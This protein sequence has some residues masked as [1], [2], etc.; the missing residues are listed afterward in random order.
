VVVVGGRGE[1]GGGLLVIAIG[2]EWSK[3]AISQFPCASVSKRVFVENLSYEKKFHL[4]ENET[5]EQI[6]I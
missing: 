6:F 5:A 4:L 1:G 3:E 2:P